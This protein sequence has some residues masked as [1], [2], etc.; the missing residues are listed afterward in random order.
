MPNLAKTVNKTP[1]KKLTIAQLCHYIYQRNYAY[2]GYLFFINLLNF[3]KKMRSFEIGHAKNVATFSELISFVTAY[4]EVYNPAKASLELTALKVMLKNGQKAIKE[5]NSNKAEH[6]AALS[7]RNKLFSPLSKLTTRV[8]NTLSVSDAPPD[9]IEN[10]KTIARKLKGE[11]A[12][13]INPN[14][15]ETKHSSTSQ[16]SFD[17]RVVNFEALV[18]LLQ[19]IPEYSPN[20]KDLQVTTLVAMH[21]SMVDANNAV[22]LANTNLSNARITRNN[23][24]YAPKTGMHATALDVKKYVKILFGTVSPKYKQISKLSFT[25]IL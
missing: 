14:N 15:T 23:V 25:A 22:I 24:L 1:N 3:S 7:D 12:V 10:A 19:S 6:K 8:V 18:L 13:K 17:N 16:M 9:L 2:P 21:K 20:E 5:V 11:R 4:G